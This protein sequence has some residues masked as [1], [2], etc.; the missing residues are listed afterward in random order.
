MKSRRLALS[1]GLATLLAAVLGAAALANSDTLGA[2]TD[3]PAAYETRTTLS[4]DYPTQLFGRPV[5]LSGQVTA[6][7]AD[8]SRGYVDAGEAELQRRDAGSSTW[9]TVATATTPG[10][11]DFSLTARRSADFRVVYP[12]HSR[13]LPSQT[14]VARLTVRR[15]LGDWV[16]R[17]RVIA[18][19][20]RVVPAWP[21][22]SVVV[23]RAAC[24]GCAWRQWRRVTTSRE[25]RF[26]TELATPRRGTWRYR[27]VVP[28]SG[29]YALSPGRKV[30]TVSR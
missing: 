28:P 17:S 15:D 13:Y 20:G 21:R 22:R 9:R 7:F 1:L 26:A 24:P 16:S 30:V 23:Q 11:L 12:G 19:R 27:A 5:R 6:P 10:D 29:G 3:T 25:S 18:L 8:G 2:D 4:L 14:S